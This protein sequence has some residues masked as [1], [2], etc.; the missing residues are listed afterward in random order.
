[1]KVLIIGDT[2]IGAAANQGVLHPELQI[3]T[4]TLDYA[5]TLKYTIDKGAE[6][7]CE[8]LIFT[9]DIF[10]HRKPTLTQQ[11]IFSQSL[12]FAV[13]RGFKD[14]HIV[15]G[16]HDQQRLSR[17]TTLGYLKELQLPNI[18][19]HD[20]F[21]RIEIKEN[22]K[23]IGNVIFM[24]YRDRKW[25]GVETYQEALAAVKQSLDFELKAIEN[26]LPRAVVG[27]F[28]IEG[29]FFNEGYADLYNE[30]QLFLPVSM[31]DKVD[32]TIMG[33]VH[34][35]TVISQTPY[36]AYVGS[37]EKRGGF[38]THDKLFAILEF[39]DGNADVNFYVEPCRAIYEMDFDFSQSSLGDKLQPK[40]MKEVE[41]FSKKNSL[42]GSIVKVNLKLLAD[43]EQFCDTKKV[44]SFLKEE[45]GV[46]YCSEI[47]P[48][49]FS[50]RQARDERIT[51]RI[52]D[53][54]AFRLFVENTVEEELKKSVL[55][56]GME[57]V[58]ALEGEDASGLD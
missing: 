4:R 14:I 33:H 16:N 24:P 52:S 42:S 17:T 58:K 55:E 54:E 29:T 32:I 43:D 5:E 35:P 2:H 28:T 45:Y 37:M 26:H 18:T 47:V 49:F 19:V 30:N 9:G 7:G 25:F 6:A 39:K 31:F 51:E 57:I 38:E 44:M 8:V 13:N 40:I 41:D 56:L 20:D 15:V 46:S 23:V 36:I 22:R 11:K 1:M 27:H 48:S 34:E 10:E 3:N 50:Q 21:D 53:R 12:H